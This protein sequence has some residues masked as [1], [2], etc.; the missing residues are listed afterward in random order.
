MKKQILYIIQ[1]AI[2]TSLLPF[3]SCKKELSEPNWDVDVL[4]P[5]ARASLTVDNIYNDSTKKVNQ[6]NSISM[7][8]SSGL[9]NYTL[10]TLFKI[11]D[12][13]ISYTAKLSNIDLGTINITHRTS[14]GDIAN[15]DM[16][17]NG[18]NSNLYQTIMNAHNS[19]TP[20]II[21]PIAEQ[22][23]DSLDIDASQYF[24]TA[25]LSNGFLD[26]KI[27]NNLPMSISN[28]IFQIRNL[29][30]N[31]VIIEDTFTLKSPDNRL[32]A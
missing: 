11:P 28:L 24:Q 7:V 25:T 15:K 26:I 18:V 27:T 4:V 23:F 17:D 32:Y 29:S 22:I 19:G 2:L 9:Y 31:Q 12:T 3:I 10:D 14:L 1:I 5:L 16:H 6:D 13:T 8:F 30:N 20:A 21:D